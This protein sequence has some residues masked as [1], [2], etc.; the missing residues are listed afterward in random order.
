[1]LH[2]QRVLRGE[3]GSGKGVKEKIGVGHIGVQLMNERSL[4]LEPWSGPLVRVRG[5]WRKVE[6]F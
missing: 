6:P 4:I 3:G 5:A 2:P 1:M